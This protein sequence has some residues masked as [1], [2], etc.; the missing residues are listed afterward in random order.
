MQILHYLVY[1]HN[2]NIMTLS[3]CYALHNYAL[4]GQKYNI[5]IAI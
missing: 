2:D 1:L 5:I 3:Y 4:F